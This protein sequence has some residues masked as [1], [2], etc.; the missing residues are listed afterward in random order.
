MNMNEE[1]KDEYETIE[2]ETETNSQISRGS[3]NSLEYEND[4]RF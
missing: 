4:N 2:S 1:S 3:M